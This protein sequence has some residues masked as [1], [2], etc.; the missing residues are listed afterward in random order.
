MIVF[1]AI[2][3]K[4]FVIVNAGEPGVMMQFGKVQAQVLGEGI[5]GDGIISLLKWLLSG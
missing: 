2:I 1:L 5:H 4:F 3:S